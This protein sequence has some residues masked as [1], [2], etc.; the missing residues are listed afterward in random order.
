MLRTLWRPWSQLPPPPLYRWIHRGSQETEPFPASP[1]RLGHCRGLR[2]PLLWAA[3]GREPGSCA[4]MSHSNECSQDESGAAIF[5]VQL[6][7]HL[8]GRAVQHREVQGF[9]SG[10]LPRLLQVR[11]QVQG[12]CRQRGQRHQ[13]P[14][15][16]LPF[17]LSGLCRCVGRQAGAQPLGLASPGFEFR[18]LLA[19]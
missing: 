7:D 19:V 1:A 6:D 5:T 13:W 14:G 4:L 18:A 16:L 9:E 11:P 8:N 15:S 2:M 17:H 10:H 12:G 3:A